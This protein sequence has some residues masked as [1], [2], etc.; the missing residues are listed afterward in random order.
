MSLKKIG[1]DKEIPYNKLVRDYCPGQTSTSLS[2]YL[3]NL[4]RF[5]GDAPFYEHCR[6]NLN[7]PR[8]NSYLGNV[9]LAE[10]KSEYVFKIIEIKQTL[11]SN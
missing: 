11:I 3:K 7:S 10:S 2:N 8:P 9:E 4:S 6:K 5:A 1:S